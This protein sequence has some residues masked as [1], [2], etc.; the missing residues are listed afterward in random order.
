MSYWRSM[1]TSCGHYYDRRRLKMWLCLSTSSYG[2]KRSLYINSEMNTVLT[3][4]Y[5]SP[6]FINILIVTTTYLPILLCELQKITQ[7]HFPVDSFPRYRLHQSSHLHDMLQSTHQYVWT[8]G[9][10][11]KQDLCHFLHSLHSNWSRLDIIMCFRMAREVFAFTYG[12]CSYWI[13]CHGNWNG[14]Y[15]IL[16]TSWV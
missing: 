9:T 6:F 10:P 7:Q 2:I 15:R 13:E 14:S 5:L 11:S 8:H 3:R 4:L 16:V 12:Q 1:C